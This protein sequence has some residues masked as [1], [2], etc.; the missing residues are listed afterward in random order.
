[1]Y[2]TLD[3]GDGSR[4]SFVCPSHE[5]HQKE[6]FEFLGGGSMKIHECIQ[7]TLYRGNGPVSNHDPDIIRV[8]ESPG[9][10]EQDY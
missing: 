6:V 4:Q 1:M 9:T 5:L 2:G 10:R 7:E 3:L 8:L